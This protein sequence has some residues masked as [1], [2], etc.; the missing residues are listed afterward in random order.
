[1]FK[2][3]PT[4]KDL[5]TDSY[6]GY[7]AREYDIEYRAIRASEHDLSPEAQNHIMDV[8]YGPR[9]AK[10]GRTFTSSAQYRLRGSD[11]KPICRNEREC[12]GRSGK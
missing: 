3:F 9:C 11:G 10:C 4:F 6:E 7:L 12:R 5:H 1:M 8:I 2:D